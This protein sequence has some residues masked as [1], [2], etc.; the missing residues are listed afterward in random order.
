MR[1]HDGSVRAVARRFGRD[2]RQ[3]YRWLE[4]FGLSEQRRGL[5]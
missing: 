5:R 4:A 2:R 3:I 1:E